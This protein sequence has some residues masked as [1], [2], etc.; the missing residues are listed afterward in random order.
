MKKVLVLVAV[1]LMFAVPAMA[2]TIVGTKHDLSTTG[3]VNAALGGT[4]DE[5]CVYCH[6]PHGADTTVSLAPLWNRVNTTLD[7]TEDLYAS[8][9][10]NAAAS[11][12]YGY[13]G[14]NGSDAVLCLS[15]HDGTSV[16]DTLVNMPN[17]GQTVATTAITNGNAL[18]L[19]D[20]EEMSN[21][22]PVGF[23]YSQV[24]GLAGE[25]LKA[26][27][28]VP[29]FEGDMWCSSCHDV[30]DNQYTP[31]LSMANGGSALCLDCHDK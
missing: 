29:L 15:C 26:A 20:T 22:H 27:P 30:H 18:I 25:E 11:A 7:G 4:I 17:S 31:F 6:T 8:S 5:I 23:C 9:T 3:P 24:Q 2:L 21:D 1:S 13:A 16:T 12:G 10:F 19:G 14:I 28:T